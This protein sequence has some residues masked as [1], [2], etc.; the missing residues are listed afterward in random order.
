VNIKIG[1][2]S[3]EDLRTVHGVKMVVLLLWAGGLVETE[4][5]IPNALGAHYCLFLDVLC[6]KCVVFACLNGCVTR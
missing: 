1:T 6:G 5:L 2:I 4:C 3:E